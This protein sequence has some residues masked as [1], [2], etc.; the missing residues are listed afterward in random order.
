L[1]LSQTEKYQQKNVPTKEEIQD[2]WKEI[3]EKKSNTL[4]KLSGSKTSA[5]KTPVWNGAQYMKHRS[6]RY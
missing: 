2:F 5:G 6:Q 4:K 1:Q 3:T